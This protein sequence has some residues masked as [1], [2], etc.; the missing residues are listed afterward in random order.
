MPDSPS[1]DISTLPGRYAPSPVS[2]VQPPD[3]W[4]DDEWQVPAAA[5][6]QPPSSIGSS[7]FSRDDRRS[8][9]KGSPMCELSQRSYLGSRPFSDIRCPELVDTKQPVARHA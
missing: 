1:L 6:I 2:E 8:H 3:L 7:Q 9:W 4:P 5:V